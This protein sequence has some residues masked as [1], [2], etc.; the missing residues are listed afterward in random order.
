MSEL[1]SAIKFILGNITNAIAI[2]FRIVMTVT[3]TPTLHGDSVTKQYT[4]TTEPKGLKNLYITNADTADLIISLLT[5]IGAEGE[6]HNYKPYIT[7]ITCQVRKQT[8]TGFGEWS[9]STSMKEQVIALTIFEALRGNYSES[10]SNAAVKVTAQLP[11]ASPSYFEKDATWDSPHD[12]EITTLNERPENN[13]VG[14]RDT[15][16]LEWYYYDKDDFDNNISNYHLFVSDTTGGITAGMWDSGILTVDTKDDWGTGGL[17]YYL[18]EVDY[19]EP[20]EYVGG[21]KVEFTFGYR[22]KVLAR[23]AF[24]AALTT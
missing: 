3:L 5:D 6:Y 14:L 12:I 21:E 13:N 20:Y 10:H 22:G 4:V 2:Q 15:A 1:V 18:A 9:S 8:N 17:I 11:V 7:D 16:L 24:R 23:M 19:P